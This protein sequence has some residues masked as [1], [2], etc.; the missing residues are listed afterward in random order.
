[1]NT[2]DLIYHRLLESEAVK[3][4]H[5]RYLYEKFDLSNRLTGLVGPR[6]VGKTTMLLQYIKNNLMDQP[7]RTFYFSADH[8]HFSDVT[9]Y[10]F[11]E[12][13]Y[14][15]N[16]T[17]HFFIDEIHKYKNWSQEI[18]NLY[19]GFPD[20]TLIFSGSSSLDLI[21]GTYDLSRRAKMFHLP[22]LSFREYIL[23]TT[24]QYIAPVSLENILNNDNDLDSITANLAGAKGLFSDYL[25]KGYYPFIQENPL[26]YYEKILA[27]IDKTIYEDIANFY[28]LKTENLQ[29]FKKILSFLVSITPGNVNIHNLGRNLK[30]DDKTISNYLGILEET[31]LVRLIYP[32]EHGNQGL[33]RPEKIF[34]NN[35]NIQYALE[36]QLTNSIEIGTIRELYFIQSIKNAGK[37]VF[38]SKD[39]DYIVED[40]V[41]EIGGRNKTRRQ[42]KNINNSFVVKDNILSSKI[43]EIPLHYLGFL[44]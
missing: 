22:G 20:I 30:V 10:S 24:G 25:S 3:S 12:D 44:Y 34:L 42:I 33:R 40:N 35:T 7:K 2:L 14:L 4:P 39:G 37:D 43:G 28:S 29:L 38:H 21:K 32:A 41:F 13:L 5:Y 23:F 18:K 6:G 36:S 19:D 9:L 8:I 11:I 27:V 17:T 26:A 31:G 15:T 16:H 1:M